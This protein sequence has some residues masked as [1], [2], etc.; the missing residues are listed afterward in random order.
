MPS[1]NLDNLERYDSKARNEAE[2]EYMPKDSG[3]WQKTE[4]AGA[5]SFYPVENSSLEGTVDF[6]F[7]E[8]P[9]ASGDKGPDNPSTIVGVESVSCNV[10]ESEGVYD[11]PYSI[12]LGGTYY[13]GTVN[14]AT[15]LMTVTHGLLE[16][17]ENTGYSSTAGVA[18]FGTIY[19]LTVYPSSSRNKSSI[20][21]QCACNIFPVVATNTSNITC[22][23]VGSNSSAVNVDIDKSL[24]GLGDG[25]NYTTVKAAFDSF[26]SSHPGV[27][28]YPI[29]NPIIVQLSPTSISALAQTDKCTPRLNTVYTDAEAIQIGYMKSPQ[30]TE[31]EL[32]QAILEIESDDSD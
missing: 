18:E 8:V 17:N 16:L 11:T 14:L 24:L 10:C 15:G 19:R 25:E 6:M 20:A 32:T 7:S 13:G 12:D 23:R 31:Q 28:V 26:F 5:V 27:F 3:N 2:E 21:S 30:R 22:I 9:P 29:A 4:K 1:I